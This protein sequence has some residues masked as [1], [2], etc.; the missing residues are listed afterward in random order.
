M[1]SYTYDSKKYI[2]MNDFAGNW[3]FYQDEI[4]IP[5]NHI[6][7]IKPLSK[8]YSNF[9]W[10]QYVSKTGEHL[11]TIENH[12]V[13][14]EL[15]EVYNFIDD[16]NQNNYSN[17]RE[18]L[19]KHLNYDYNDQIFFFWGCGTS[20]ETTWEIFLRHW[21]N[22]LFEDEGPILIN[23]RS[24]KVIIFGSTGSV[25]IGLKKEL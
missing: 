12:E 2:D 7:R 15:Q 3:F 14:L 10:K 21:I 11:M 4:M 20:V 19:Q 24:K 6:A 8:K 18:E 25:L 23:P 1:C 17:L 5:Q 9:L 16:W 22:F 13:L